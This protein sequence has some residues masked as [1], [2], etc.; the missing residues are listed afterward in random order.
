VQLFLRILENF[1][2][3]VGMAPE[4]Q[5]SLEMAARTIELPCLLVQDAQVIMNFDDVMESGRI[6]TIRPLACPGEHLL[7]AA[8]GV[9]VSV[10]SG[11]GARECLERKSRILKAD[12]FLRSVHSGPGISLREG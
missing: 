8:D 7:I 6:I 11:I 10:R 5:K 4:S 12:R 9:V 2:V 3:G 1:Q